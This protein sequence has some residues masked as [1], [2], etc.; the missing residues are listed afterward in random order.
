MNTLLFMMLVCRL[1]TGN[2]RARLAGE[3]SVITQT[4][5]FRNGRYTKR[6]KCCGG[7]QFIDRR[8]V[9]VLAQELSTVF[10]DKK[11]LHFQGPNNC[12]L[13]NS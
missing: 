3:K 2:S 4:V 9:L 10:I 7:D 8:L 11:I 1:A 5:N 6:L 13:G 12:L